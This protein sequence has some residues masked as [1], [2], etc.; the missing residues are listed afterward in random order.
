MSR[1]RGGARFSALLAGTL[2]AMS[3]SLACFAAPAGAKVVG[4]ATG[5]G[6][7]AVGLQ[8]RNATSFLDGGSGNNFENPNGSPVLH[9]TIA[10][11]GIETYAIYWDPTDHYHGDWQHLINTFL[12]DVGAEGGAFSNVFSVGTQYSDKTN[13]PAASHTTFRGSYTDTNAYPTAGCT[14]PQPLEPGDAITCITD[15]QLRTELSSFV[16][17][18][19]LQTGM[20]SIFYLL[21]P[22]GVTVC[23]DEGGSASHCSSNTANAN[24]FCSYHSVINPDAAINGDASTILYADIPWVAGGLGDYH[25][26]PGSR[27]TESYA[28]QDGGFDPSTRPVAELKEK[29]KEKNEAEKEAFTKMDAEEKSVAVEA[30]TREGPHAQQPNQHGVGPDGTPDTGLPDVLIN[31]IAEEQQNTVTD[32]LLN[33]WQGQDAAHDEVTDEC[34]NFFD[35][36]G[37]GGASGA[38]EETDAGTLSNQGLAGHAYYLNTTFNLAA[39]K[40]PFPA[41][42]CLDGINLRPEFTAPSPVNV[43][44][45]V[46]FDGMESDISLNASD[47]FG[48]GGTVTNTYAKYTWDFGDETA[49][50]TGFA[51]GA[52][53]CTTP[54]LSPCAASVFHSYQYGGEYHVRLTVTD[55]GG[56]TFSETHAVVVNGPAKPAPPGPPPPAAATATGSGSSA[57]SPGGTSG[58]S[59]VAGS[60]T[61]TAPPVATAAVASTSLKTVLK[62][63]L[64]VRYSVNEQVTGHFEVLLASS[65]ARRIGLH[66]SQASGL[67]KGTA[68]QIVIAKAI[69][70]TT[71]GGRSSIKILFGKKTAKLLKRLPTV[72]LMVRLVVRNGSA[73]SPT[74]TV[75]SVVTLKH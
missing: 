64:A 72:S 13:T 3:L 73:L 45:I 43:N 1:P 62:T 67:P 17:A 50:V 46:G 47:L 41:V 2:T 27:N 26:H 60:G 52:P 18:H 19:G 35:V 33:A 70:V 49:P 8:P 9:G 23:V 53:A 61:P 25:L 7:T 40:L 10:S 38:N 51:P 21:T 22:P 6:T 14:D 75:V 68:P 4:I 32:P 12:H 58:T 5:S 36:A 16:A 39:L 34:R 30:E 56:N 20:G 55:V 31:Q 59:T 74:S 65:I 24:S 44:E 69:L 37:L 57:A 71:K 54:W 66:G 42:P 28:C 48:P 29:V 15:K 63:G 11:G